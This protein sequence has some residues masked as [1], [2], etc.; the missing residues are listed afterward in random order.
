M[1]GTLAAFVQ[2]FFAWEV[3]LLRQLV[4]AKSNNPATSDHTLADN[5]IEANVATIISQALMHLGYQAQFV[6]ASPQRPNVF[7]AIPGKGL[8][9]TLILSTHMD[10]VEP[11][12]Y[13]RDPWG[14]QIEQGK[15]YGVGVA[16]AKAQIAAFL[17]AVRA[18]HQVTEHLAGNLILA[19]VVDEEVGA[20]SPYGTQYLFERGLLQGDAA[21]IGEPGHDKIAIGHRGLYRF[22]L[23]IT[24]EAAHTGLKEWEQGRVGRNAILD[25]ARFAQALADAPLPEVPSA[26]FP[27][28]KSVLTF[29][30]L[31]Q[32]GSGIN[33]VPR[34]CEAYGD[35]RLLP[36]FPSR[37]LKAMLQDHLYRL[38]I[39]H[40][41]LEDVVDIPAVEINQQEAIVQH[42]ATA[43]E[44][45][46]GERPR[47]EGVGPACDG[48]MYIIRGIPAIC[49]YG[50]K[51]GGVHGAD[52]WVDLA[53]LQQ[54][55]EIYARTILSY[56]C[57][58]DR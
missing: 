53:S 30:T 56:L 50:V 5:P 23:Q 38:G 2:Q 34:T 21:M 27:Q 25:M 17:A 6:G 55:T 1:Q 28:R 43:A 18:V 31:I 46:T 51:C 3:D 10:T 4:R 35:A 36:G 45:V 40:Y 11:A 44:A 15:M 42:L 47:L 22:R 41:T 14:A 12:G 29:P 9:K 20:C 8:Q 48:W 32:G 24:G 7:C 49:G 19:F 52:E 37:Q 16:D 54:T 33:V 13:T 58:D 57:D 26:A 39:A